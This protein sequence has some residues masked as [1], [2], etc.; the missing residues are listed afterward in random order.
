MNLF[1]KI[2]EGNEVA[3]SQGIT[4]LESSLESDNLFSHRLIDDCL[5]HSG[6][7]IR[8]GI[9]GQSWSWKKYFHRKFWQI[10]NLQWK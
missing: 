3:L 2:R 8:I 10:V 4:L 9:T 7:S 5:P 1:T 6:N